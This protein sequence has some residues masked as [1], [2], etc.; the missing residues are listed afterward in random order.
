MMAAFKELHAT[1]LLLLLTLANSFVLP[2]QHMQLEVYD[3]A[4][5]VQFPARHSGS[6]Q[7]EDW[8]EPAPVSDLI[9]VVDLASANEAG[10]EEVKEEEDSNSY[11]LPVSPDKKKKKS[12]KKKENEAGNH[13]KTKKQ[14]FKDVLSKVK[15]KSKKSK[16]KS[17]GN[18]KKSKT[19]KHKKPKN[20]EAKEKQKRKKGKQKRKR[21]EH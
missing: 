12:K 1:V 20:S 15:S 8:V 2:N 16:P 21:V 4:P 11:I 6:L 19:G 7:V 3:S 9:P 17:K 18:T 5:L 14:Q 13:G 10:G